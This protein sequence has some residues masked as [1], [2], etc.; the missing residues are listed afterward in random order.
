MDCATCT[1]QASRVFP[2][3]R[4][5][6]AGVRCFLPPARSKRCMPT[7]E[8]LARQSIDAQLIACGWTVQNRPEVNLHAGQGVA[9]REFPLDTG[10]TDYLLFVDQKASD[11]TWLRDESL[12]ESENLPEPGVLAREIMEELKV[13]LE[14]FSSMPGNWERKSSNRLSSPA[15]ARG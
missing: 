13:A 14:Q 5:G 2:P 8:A 7:P 10:Y 1:L 12:E 11:I 15:P 6:R 3:S 9:V 4:P